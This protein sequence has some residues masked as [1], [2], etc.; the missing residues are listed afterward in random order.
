[1]GRAADDALILK[2]TPLVRQIAVSLAKRL[3]G[4]IDDFVQSGMIG[5]IQAARRFD[6]TKGRNFRTY[7]SDRIRGAI[8]DNFWHLDTIPRWERAA[9]KKDPQRKSRY[10]HSRRAV[11]SEKKIAGIALVEADTIRARRDMTILTTALLYQLSPRHLD[12]MY[13]RYFK[14]MKDPEIAAVYGVTGSRICQI[15]REAEHQLREAA[16]KM[17]VSS[18]DDVI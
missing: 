1:V 15:R 14:E 3:G 5:L 8:L 11:E 10:L 16:A 2:S 6:E 12:V 9:R 4:E 17:K 18:I 13:M 7:A